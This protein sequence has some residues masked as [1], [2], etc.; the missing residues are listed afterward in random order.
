MAILVG[1]ASW[2]DKSLVDSGKFYPPDVTSPE[3]R[4]RYYAMPLPATTQHWAERTPEHFVFNV[5]A[6]RLF[7]G[8]QAQPRVLPK[9]LQ[10]AL[11]RPLHENVYYRD[12]PQEIQKE[13]WGR[14]FLAL[15]PLHAAGKLGAIHFQFAPWITSGGDARQLVE[16]CVRVM[17]GTTMAVEFRNASWWN[18]RNRE[19]TLAFEREHGLV[20][21]VVDG[22]QV[23]NSVP[24]VWEVTSPKLAVVRMHGRNHETWNKKGLKAAS[25]RFNYDYTDNELGEIATQVA[26]FSKAVPVVHAVLNNNYEDQ[27]QRNAKTLT[28]LVNA[29]PTPAVGS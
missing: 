12:L 25:D 4:L 10:E 21:V 26:E 13:L 29:A 17:E 8:H 3:E 23:G 1:T 11:G 20:N 6:F 14:F 7:T 5:K 24:A 16:H 2:A 22:R 15:E 28:K 9:D 27:G 19:S 18:E